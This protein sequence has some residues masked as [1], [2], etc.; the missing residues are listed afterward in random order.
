MDN[1]KSLSSFLTHLS[2][3]FEMV[4]LTCLELTK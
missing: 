3:V 1:L 4:S 2:L